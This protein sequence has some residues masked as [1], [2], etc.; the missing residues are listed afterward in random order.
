MMKGLTKNTIINKVT[1][2]LLVFVVAIVSGFGGLSGNA[3]I[4]QGTVTYEKETIYYGEG[5]SVKYTIDSQWDNQY[6]ANVV[7][8]NTGEKPIENWELFYESYDEYSNLWNAK[9]SYRSARI[10]NIKNAGYNQNIEPDQ[11]VS[12]GF[13]ATFNKTIDIPQSYKLLGETAEIDESECQVTYDIRNQWNNG[14]IIDITLYNN[15][16]E[17][18]ENWS[19]KFDFNSRIDNIWRAKIESYEGNTYQVK[20]CGYNF[21]I[22]PDSS[23]TIGMQ[24]RFEDG[25]TPGSID[26]I[27]VSQSK[28][29]KSYVEFDKEWNRT[30]VRADSAVVVEASEKNPY[31]IK[32]GLIDSGVDYSENINIVDRE[33][34]VEE[35]T[36]TNPIFDDLS[37]HGT[38]VAGL[39]ASNSNVESDNFEFD[40]KNLNKLMNEKIQ[41]INPYIN[42][43]SARVLDDNNETTV[44]RLMAAIEWAIDKEVNIININCGISKDNKQLH[45]V[46]KKAYN[47]GILIIAAAGNDNSIQYPA[48]YSEVMAVGSVKCDGEQSSASATG[49]E[50][51]VVAPGQDVTSYGPFGILDSYS[52]SSMAT[53]QVTA[54]AAILWQQDLTKSSEF[55]RQLIDVSAN[56][57]GSKEKFGYGMIDCEYALQKYEEFEKYYSDHKTVVENVD[58]NLENALIECNDKDIICIEEESVEGYWSGKNHFATVAQSL[59]SIQRG[60]VWPDKKE[61]EVGGMTSNPAF[62]G[63]YQNDSGEEVNYVDAYIFMTKVAANMYKNGSN[64]STVD[65]DE[66]WLL[67]SKEGNVDEDFAKTIKKA[68]EAGFEKYKY[69]TKKDKANFIYGMALHTVADIFAHSTYAIKGTSEDRKSMLNKDIKDLVPD[70]KR[71]THGPK[72]DK[73]KFDSKKNFADMVDCIPIRYNK[74]AKNVCNEILNTAIT[75]HKAGTSN[76]FKK[77][78]YYKEKNYKNAW[79]YDSIKQDKKETDEE[80]QKRIELLKKKYIVYSYGIIN[81]YTYVGAEKD[82]ELGKLTKQVDAKEMKELMKSWIAKEAGK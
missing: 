44:S 59:K 74:S 75:K 49:E 62:H 32:I 73:G 68:A 61:S 65:K 76:V 81:F 10:Y 64:K 60:V 67:T 15:S 43:Y 29:G 31:S 17:D 55:I 47:K 18:I 80:Y 63:Y 82:T 38:A 34:F 3:N 19:M 11:S 53:S 71:L 26:N 12:F 70:W 28:K 72:D 20:N 35:Y 45:D 2:G 37:G 54:L 48:K 50:L 21:V 5:F 66:V 6:I 42:I 52:G 33:N 8:T 40:D 13:Q 39:M 9:I 14:C 25:G 16:D 79:E 51:E 46:I 36:E 23:E 7:L 4:V 56:K 58:H 24:V 57:L 30:M 1:A 27:V 77:V 69:K 41:G 78:E 22:P